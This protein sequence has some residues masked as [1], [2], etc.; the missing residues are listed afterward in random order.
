M[1]IWFDEIMV[2]EKGRAHD[3]L[4]TTLPDEI[5][6]S[7]A[8]HLD[9]PGQ[10]PP[11][12]QLES[13][14]S[15]FPY[16]NRYVFARTS[17]DPRAARQGMVFSHALVAEA[18]S[19][20]SLPDVV[21][22]FDRLKAIRPV[23]FNPS[24]TVITLTNNRPTSYPSSELCDLLTTLSDGPAIIV[25]PSILEESIVALWPRLLPSMRSELRFRM[26]FG[27]EEADISRMHIVAVP[28]ITAT[29]WPEGRVA[30]ALGADQQEAHTAGGRF[31][32]GKFE[33]D[34][35]KFLAGLSIECT[36][37]K[38]LDLCCRALELSINEEDFSKALTGLRLIGIL[39]PAPE[40]GRAVKAACLDRV[41]MLPGPKSVSDFLSIRNLDLSPF[42]E[43]RRFK[44]HLTTSFTGLLEC[45]F[46][47][48][49]L[50][51]VVE[52]AFNPAQA[53]EDWREA[54]GA[55]LSNLSPLAA[56][57]FAPLIWSAYSIRRDL[58][59]SVLGAV[60]GVPSMDKTLSTHIDD[61]GELRVEDISEDLI[62]VNFFLA[63]A[64]FVVNRFGGDLHEAL[65]HACK[66]D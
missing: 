8:H 12:V 10:L 44:V 45:D 21:S 6:R 40:K 1:E 9:L 7:L 23:S 11:G 39:Q 43:R 58:A 19:I 31:L 61:M 32:T 37:F 35:P 52:S 65:E 54:I 56:N 41:A 51:P 16:G 18:E 46:S 63:E 14:V 47:T 22:V 3:V 48:D 28:T 49:A 17:W 36:S 4:T 33:R 25:G 29:R 2:G 66:R 42:A 27:P 26:S 15:G 57:N 13:Y 24:K 5:A 62:E 59:Q 38:K 50:L 34:L 30:A 20:S 55:A 53:T 60:A 64:S